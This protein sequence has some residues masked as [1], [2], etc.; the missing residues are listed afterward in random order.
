[1]SPRV[2]RLAAQA[3]TD[4]RRFIA[5]SLAAGGT[6]ALPPAALGQIPDSGRTGLRGL[7]PMRLTPDQLI[8]LKCCLRPLRASG[9]NLA[10]ET[11]GRK[12]VVHNYGHGGSGWSLSWGSAEVAVGKALTALPA[13]V[14]V[15]GC[16]I[17]G[18]TSAIVAQRSGLPVT[19]YARE[20]LPQTRSFRA[21]GSYTPGSRIALAEPAGP[22]FPVLW[23]QMARFSWKMF[24]TMLGLPG[25][26]VAFADSY[27]V[28]DEPIERRTWSPDPAI[29]ETYESS[30]L[31]RQNAEFAHL[32][33]RIRDI[34]PQAQP[35]A[36]DGNPF[37]TQFATRTSQMHFN[38]PSYGRMLL[39]EFFGRGGR[40]E[41]RRFHAPGELADL[42]E[43][44]VIHATGFAA[45]DF[46]GDASVIPVRGQ[47]GWLV[48]QEGVNYSLRHRNVSALAKADGIVIMN[49]NP[50][51]GDMLGVGDSLELPDRT[52]IEQ[53]MATL[54]GIFAR[55]PLA[56]GDA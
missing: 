41:M 16:G 6:V 4:R 30:G 44:V 26:P 11:V 3:T 15:I 18:L 7:V 20:M 29:T 22:N 23:E 54:A 49:N 56:R 40:F 12:L 28:S 19:I 37:A 35:L 45:R 36:A 21:S 27:A 1:M 52:P 39:D 51:L 53:G 50:D 2:C 47:T 8:D 46:W 5:G 9:P 55:P 17:I 48:P 31:P 10:T 32:D 14:A 25:N 33:S 38:F 34:V 13:S 43:D 42:P 24:R